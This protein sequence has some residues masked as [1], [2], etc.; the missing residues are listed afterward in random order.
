[1]KEIV[2]DL[3]SY[4]LKPDTT[5]F[6]TTNGEWNAKGLAV[7]GRGCAKEAAERFHGIRSQL[8]QLL[9]DN[10]NVV[11]ELREG[12]WSFPVKHHW[13]ERADIELITRS[14]A[15]V[16]GM[17]LKAPEHTFVIPRPG[18]ANG[19]L[20]WER[21]VRPHMIPLFGKLDNVSFITKFNI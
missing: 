10:G 3:W 9:R 7:M 11:Q 16:M 14:A 8:A 13:K 1:M 18:C 6:I 21:D 12:L 17:A 4:Y 20:D 19:K 2:G 5:I 15:T